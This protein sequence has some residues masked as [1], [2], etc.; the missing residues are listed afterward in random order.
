MNAGVF[1]IRYYELIPEAALLI[2]P[3]KFMNTSFIYTNN[4]PICC[5]LVEAMGQYCQ[6][7]INNRVCPFFSIGAR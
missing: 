5:W 4:G 2:L 6:Q 3:N 1:S 7:I